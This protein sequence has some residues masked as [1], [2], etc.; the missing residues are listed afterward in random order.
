MKP[1][2]IAACIVI[3]AVFALCVAVPAAP[4]AKGRRVKKIKIDKN[5]LSPL[6]TFK[7]IERAWRKADAEVLSAHTS[8]S[9]VFLRLKG[10]N[11]KEGYFSR[12][13]AYFLL[14]NMFEANR[15][16]KF[17]FVKYHKLENINR[18]VYGIAD[19]SYKNISNGR[20][21]RDKVYVTLKREGE[22]WVV[23]EIK[24]AG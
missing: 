1:F 17:E 24:S 16:V 13:Q 18:K 23:A 11:R 10:I 19:R 6:S 22:K 4:Q 14:K 9:R 2:R 8:N 7:Q 15:Q 3:A 21:F 5:K 12:P 20:L